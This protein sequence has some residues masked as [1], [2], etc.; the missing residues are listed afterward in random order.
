MRTHFS[1]R[2]GSRLLGG[3][4]EKAGTSEGSKKAWEVRHAKGEKAEND[5]AKVRRARKKELWEQRSKLH[6][7]WMAAF[8]DKERPDRREVMARID[9]EKDKIRDELAAIT[10]EDDREYEESRAKRKREERERRAADPANTKEAKAETKEWATTEVLEYLDTAYRN[11]RER[12]YGKEPTI[13]TTL[14]IDIL[15]EG[16]QPPHWDNKT[17]KAKRVYIDRLMRSLKKQGK[18]SSSAAPGERGGEVMAWEPYRGEEKARAIVAAAILK[19]GTSGGA[20]K[21]WEKR[22]ARY[23]KAG[24]PEKKQRQAAA[25]DEPKKP[26][27]K[28]KA[29]PKAA[30]PAPPAEEPKAPR[31]RGTRMTKKQMTA[32]VRDIVHPPRRRPKTQAAL[33]RWATWLDINQRSNASIQELEKVDVP[34]EKMTVRAEALD[35]NVDLI[36]REALRKTRL[37]AAREH[38]F[39]LDNETA[40][41]AGQFILGTQ[42]SCNIASGLA[43]MQPDKGYT[44]F[45]TH[46]GHGGSFSD[47]DIWIM[48]KFTQLTHSVVYGVGGWAYE[49]S[50]PPGWKRPD[51]LSQAAL[52]MQFDSH[53]RLALGAFRQEAERARPHPGDIDDYREWK[54]T[55]TDYHYLAFREANHYATKKIAEELG[56]EYRRYRLP[57]EGEEVAELSSTF[58]EN[59]VRRRFNRPEVAKSLEGSADP[60]ANTP[61]DFEDEIHDDLPPEQKI[62]DRK[63]FAQFEEF[64]ASLQDE[65]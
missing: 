46:P 50:K 41:P 24:T 58:D 32:Y 10:A 15:D 39:F 22:R 7:E 51:N 13:S 43:E 62:D 1:E 27:R 61:T 57:G 30:P 23:G 36:G 9:E 38:A 63:L 17:R 59:A 20:K 21:A 6:D 33:K 49:M 53:L 26:R 34:T 28:K 65:K 11:W 47:P 44:M 12:E 55:V 54:K 31:P 45:H 19:A 18:V 48:A 3:L 5:P 2:F 64:M 14:L 16:R 25:P 37:K 56:L 29:E 8:S 52:G 4:V 35:K 60:S 40:K 42:G